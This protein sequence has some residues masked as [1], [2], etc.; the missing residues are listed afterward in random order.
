[1]GRTIEQLEQRVR[2][3]E[4]QFANL[5]LTMAGGGIGGGQV[6]R[7]VIADEC[8]VIGAETACHFAS[9]GKEVEVWATDGEGP[10]GTE[11]LALKEGDRWYGFG[12]GSF[13]YHGECGPVTPGATVTVTI[14][15]TEEEIEATDFLG[16]TGEGEC[17]VFFQDCQ[18]WIIDVNCSEGA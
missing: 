9:N 12:V 17:L 13:I 14:S 7:R 2:A 5:P 15:A 16:Y 6:V 18:W 3:L 1:M 11:F 4:Q 10:E 8:I